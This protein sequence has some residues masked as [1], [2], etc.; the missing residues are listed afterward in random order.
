MDIAA[1][2]AVTHLINVAAANIFFMCNKSHILLPYVMIR[3]GLKYQNKTIEVKSY[4]IHK[5]LVNGPGS[6]LNTLSFST[7][8]ENQ[9]IFFPH[10][11]LF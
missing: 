3:R 10:K 11:H 8:K 5:K 2:H 9:K 7:G 4:H 6:K 1:I